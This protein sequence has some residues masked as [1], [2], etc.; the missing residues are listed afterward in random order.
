MDIKSLCDDHISVKTL[1]CLN[2]FFFFTLYGKGIPFILLLCEN[3]HI[4]EY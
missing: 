2:T 3:K 1:N 4:K